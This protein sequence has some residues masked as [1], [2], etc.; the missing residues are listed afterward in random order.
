MVGR[1]VSLDRYLSSATSARAV[2]AVETACAH[3]HCNG[4]RADAPEAGSCAGMRPVT[5][6]HWGIRAASPNI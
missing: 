4:E 6:E 1:V 2:D 3:Q 5:A